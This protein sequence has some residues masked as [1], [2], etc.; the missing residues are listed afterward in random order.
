M[1]NEQ[2]TLLFSSNDYND[3]DL[4]RLLELQRR[5]SELRDASMEEFIVDEELDD[6]DDFSVTAPSKKRTTHTVPDMR[7]EKQFEKSVQ[8][9]KENGAS[10]LTIVW[11]TIIKDQIIM[12]FFSGFLWNVS[13][14]AWKWYRTRGVVNSGNKQFGIF[15]G[16]KYHVSQWTK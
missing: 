16:V 4:A 5:Q 7:F 12:P 15:K 11:S 10:T 9:L 8:H 3:E 1:A 13:G 14:V 6:D 2:D